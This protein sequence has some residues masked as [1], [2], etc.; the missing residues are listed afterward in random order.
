MEP[1]VSAS[2]TA[3]PS[4]GTNKWLEL[5]SGSAQTTILSV[6][7]A[8]W[9]VF[10][11]VLGVLIARKRA[12][13]RQRRAQSTGR[14][15]VVPGLQQQSTRRGGK[16]KCTLDAGELDLLPEVRYG[17]YSEKAHVIDVEGGADVCAICLELFASEAR[18]RGLA[19]AHVF[20]SDCI[21][22]WLLKRSSRCPLCNQDSR[23]LNA[24]PQLPSAAKLADQV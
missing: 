21:D 10:A 7:F 15:V 13:A 8:V 19:C 22:K 16:P 5:S 9:V 18:V 1:T 23:G 20:H 12:A 17:E 24:E 2:P 14:I 4:D 6:V 11:I 3:T